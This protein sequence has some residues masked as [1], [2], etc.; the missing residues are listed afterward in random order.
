M[1]YTFERVLKAVGDLVYTFDIGGLDDLTLGPGAGLVWRDNL[2]L[3]DD[4]G[5]AIVAAIVAKAM[6]NFARFGFTEVGVLRKASG[7]KYMRRLLDM[8]L[9]VC[10]RQAR[11]SKQPPSR[12][13]YIKSSKNRQNAGQMVG[14]GG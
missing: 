5:A 8:P 13:G 9:G 12:P 1:T 3:L 6:S 2:G 10:C 7:G 4:S 11:T 14:T